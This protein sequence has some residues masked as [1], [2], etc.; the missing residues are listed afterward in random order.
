MLADFRLCFRFFS[1]SSLTKCVKMVEHVNRL[2][3]DFQFVGFKLSPLSYSESL[4]F[5]FLFFDTGCQHRT[6]GRPR[7]IVELEFWRSK[8][9]VCVKLCRCV[10]SIN[11]L[12]VILKRDVWEAKC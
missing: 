7:R 5:S 3:R 12:F 6:A 11:K 2:A 9:V 1:E 4:F 8:L 10:A